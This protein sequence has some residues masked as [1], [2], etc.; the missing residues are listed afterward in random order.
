MFLGSLHRFQVLWGQLKYL[1]CMSTAHLGRSECGAA[2][3]R[4][5]GEPSRDKWYYWGKILVSF[6]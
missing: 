4:N 6:W 1:D 5:R 2:Q 3:Q